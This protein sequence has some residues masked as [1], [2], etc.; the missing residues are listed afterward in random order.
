MEDVQESLAPMNLASI[1]YS[2]T[3]IGAGPVLRLKAEDNSRSMSTSANPMA[4]VPSPNMPGDDAGT[5]SG[6]NVSQEWV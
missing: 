6:I 2:R 3:L 1:R 4:G 5:S